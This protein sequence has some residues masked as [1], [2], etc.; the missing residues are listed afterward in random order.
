MVNKHKCGVI[1]KPLKILKPIHFLGS[2]KYIYYITIM[3]CL[4]LYV[5]KKFNNILVVVHKFKMIVL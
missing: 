2:N 1:L 3:N 5:S 4:I